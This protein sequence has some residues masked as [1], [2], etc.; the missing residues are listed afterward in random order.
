MTYER[1]TTDLR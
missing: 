1:F